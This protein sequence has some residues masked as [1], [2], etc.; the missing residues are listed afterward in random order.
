MRTQSVLALSA[1]AAIA[2]LA[3]AWIAWPN[4]EAATLSEVVPDRSEASSSQ[5]LAVPSDDQPPPRPQ[6]T[7]Q[8]TDR[9]EA[10][11]P[12]SAVWVFVQQA[13]NEEPIVGADVY[14]LDPVTLPEDVRHLL[15][16]SWDGT[17]ERIV[18][19]HG[20]RFV[21][22]ERGLVQ[23]PR[24]SK[25][26]LIYAEASGCSDLQKRGQMNKVWLRLIVQPRVT[27]R[28]VDE[29]GSPVPHFPVALQNRSSSRASTKSLA[30]TNKEGT[31]RFATPEKELLSTSWSGDSCVAAAI[32]GQSIESAP[33]AWSK[34][35]P[36][37]LNGEEIKLVIPPHGSLQVEAIDSHPTGFERSSGNRIL[38][39]GNLQ[40]GPV[41]FGSSWHD[42]ELISSDSQQYPFVAL[43]LEFQ[44]Q[45]GNQEINFLGPTLPGEKLHKEIELEREQIWKGRL[46]GPDGMPIPER[47]FKLLEQ[48]IDAVGDLEQEWTFGVTDTEGR[49]TVSML[50]MNTSGDL[51]H[52]VG[53]G[54]RGSRKGDPLVA[55]VDL[56]KSLNTN[57]GDIQLEELPVQ[58]RGVIRDELGQ[59]VPNARLDVECEWKSQYEEGS[60]MNLS[61][62][63]SEIMDDGEFVIKSCGPLEAPY[64]IKASAD[65]FKTEYG[66][67]AW[68]DDDIE[69]ILQSKERASG[70][71]T[72][73]IALGP[74][75]KKSDLR[76]RFESSD[77]HGFYHLDLT[78]H[79]DGNASFVVHAQVNEKIQISIFTRCGEVLYQSPQLS[80]AD[81]ETLE[82]GEV[83]SAQ[84]LRPA[85]HW[86]TT[87]EDG[88]PVA[89]EFK[90]TTDYHSGSAYSDL[91]GCTL[92]TLSPIRHV[93]VHAPGFVPQEIVMPETSQTIVLER[94][95]D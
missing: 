75:A 44:A 34:I 71:I 18:K 91:E 90:V 6:A 60:W 2:A 58:I 45:H 29:R 12:G 85:V 64:R 92:R 32:Y 84:N 50:M 76:L 20:L 47:E 68:A 65:G 41:L 31:A 26:Q 30:W 83:A 14:S 81:D 43:G 89:A 53:I 56:G 79:G 35:E 15:Q 69:I 88:L 49:F 72:G 39:H 10:F 95:L 48:T 86:K 21:S 22:A 67:E 23:I 5:L 37:H 27:V 40:N 94:K 16:S 13:G 80:V 24:G 38:V 3:V 17:A 25:E 87:D 70:Q 11:P 73:W 61:V 57:L 55:Q 42:T 52:C 28:V 36:R 77:M 62:H 8:T 93:V 7:D 78:P 54:L 33:H 63:T 19:E 59:V 74:W 82:L 46:I 1:I 51:R 4:P 66:I 9:S